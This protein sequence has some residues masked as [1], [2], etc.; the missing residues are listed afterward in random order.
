[1]ARPAFRWLVGFCLPGTVTGPITTDGTI[2]ARVAS[3]ILS[4]NLNL[5][6]GVNGV[7]AASNNVTA[8]A[9]GLC[10]NLNSNGGL[11]NFFDP[12]TGSPAGAGFFISKLTGGPSSPCGHAY[13]GNG[14]V[15]ATEK[16]TS[17]CAVVSPG[18]VEP[19]LR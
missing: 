6:D 18:C 7:V 14:A 12:N 15:P 4:F 8:T 11:M 3:N 19:R 13:F 10:F 9:T 16:S 17:D 5:L 2:G 1:M